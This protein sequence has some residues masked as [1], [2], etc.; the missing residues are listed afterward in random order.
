MTFERESLET[1]FRSWR[2]YLTW[3]IHKANGL[4]NIGEDILL[5][6]WFHFWK[7][8]SLNKWKQRYLERRIILLQRLF[9]QWKSL[10][11]TKEDRFFNKKVY[12]YEWR[13]RARAKS[14]AANVTARIV[15]KRKIIQSMYCIRRWK[16]AYEE[17][18][19]NIQQS[20]HSIRKHFQRSRHLVSSKYIRDTP[21]ILVIR[22][23][24]KVSFCTYSIL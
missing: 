15:M 4:C 20:E 5:K 10:C 8:N 16:E 3:G 21:F 19:S 12:F 11:T 24:R 23:W 14:H 2:R 6:K 13:N 7:D 1:A 9:D 17:H 22:F 18:I